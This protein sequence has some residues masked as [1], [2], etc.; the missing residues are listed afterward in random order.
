MK[1]TSTKKGLFIFTIIITLSIIIGT[2]NLLFSN[3][4]IKIEDYNETK[5]SKISQLKNS[6]KHYIGI[7]HITGVISESSNT[8]NQ[9]WILNL[10]N[11]LKTD[12]KNYGILLYIN[13]PGG[14]VYQADEV[15]LALEDYKKTGKKVF[16]YFGP[17]AASG[18]YYIACASDKI[19]AN[20]NT[21][22]GSIGVISGNS[23]DI[24]ELLKKIGIK[25]TT[26][27]AGKNKNMFNFNSPVTE[28]QSNIMQEIANECYNQFVN[29]VAKGRNLKI[30][31]VL[32]LA[33]GRIYTA[34]QALNNKLIDEICSWE[35]A[36]VKIITS[37]ENKKIIYK[38]YKYKE[39][40][41]LI[42][43][44]NGV[45][46]LITSPQDIFAKDVSMPLY[47]YSTK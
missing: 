38:E 46:T 30:E 9:K 12:S 39:K 47:L 15:Y 4:N 17:L 34:N 2:Y 29:I 8:Y 42:S 21:L 22:T 3:K 26:I 41:S 13:S 6:N 5:F 19:F 28:E 31:D 44:I 7:I 14:G 33:D 23:F 43:L 18:G 20:R 27:T 40:D 35:E 16:S 36:K 25:S 11:S 37:E 10:I 1:D 24:T 45:S 32:I